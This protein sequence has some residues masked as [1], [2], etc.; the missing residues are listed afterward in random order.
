MVD[1]LSA[2]PILTSHARRPLGKG[3]L[4]VPRIGWGLWRFRGDDVRAARARVD[5]AIEAG[6]DLFDAADVYGPD[7]G[8]PFGAAEALLGRVFAEAPS[9]RDRVVLATKGGIEVFASNG[10]WSKLFAWIRTMWYSNLFT[11]AEPCGGE[12]DAN[13]GP[14]ESDL[15]A[16]ATRM[17]ISR[18]ATRS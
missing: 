15:A 6:L 4:S 10:L 9:L 3:G 16:S 14:A 8:E 5:A 12:L 13:G 11:R 1:V 18:A 2:A 7:N 17:Q